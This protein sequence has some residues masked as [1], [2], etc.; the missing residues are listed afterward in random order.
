M[1]KLPAIALL[2][3]LLAPATVHAREEKSV[4]MEAIM[5]EIAAL[6]SVVEAQ[7]RQIDQLQA[8]LRPPAAQP[9]QAPQPTPA[10]AQAGDLEKRGY[11]FHQ[12]RRF[13]TQRRL[14]P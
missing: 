10:N 12:S 3:A 8:A 6:R 11:A 4:S 14:S 7:Q 13:Q 1:M 9:P 5:E 2:I